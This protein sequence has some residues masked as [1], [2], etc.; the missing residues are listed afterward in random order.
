MTKVPQKIF[1][2]ISDDFQHLNSKLK[3]SYYEAFLSSFT[4]GIAENFFAAFA[5]KKGMTTLQSGLL[6]TLPLFIAILCNAYFNIR[7][8]GQQISQVVINNVL[9]QALSLFSLFVLSY[10]PLS[11]EY[12]VFGCLICIFSIYWYGFYSSQPAWN[13]WISEIISEEEGQQYFSFRSRLAQVGVISGLLFGAVLINLNSIPVSTQNLFALLFFTG[14]VCQYLKYFALKK[15]TPTESKTSFSYKKIKTIYQNN[16]KFFHNYGLFNASLFLSAPYVTGYLLND[17]NV[18][19]Q[20]FITITMGLFLGKIATTYILSIQNKDYIPTKLML[21]GGALAAPLPALWPLTFN[22]PT[23][24][25]LHFTSGMAW[26]LWEVGLSLSFLKNISKKDKVET[27]SLYQAVGIFTQLV[28]ML[29]GAVLMKIGFNSNLSHLF[30][31]SG[32]IRL[33]C[34]IPFSKTQFIQNHE[35]KEILSA[36]SASQKEAS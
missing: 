3:Y 25:C 24:F 10:V 27:I 16:K 13:H 33:L 11:N 4:I 34:M 29:L 36:K 22:I 19:Y 5:I 1:K 6:L 23:M 2:Q 26:A 18:G 20:G 9:L 8:Q 32:I 7:K 35:N 15:H 30:I 31:L 28:G 17:R 14:M 21:I 12:V